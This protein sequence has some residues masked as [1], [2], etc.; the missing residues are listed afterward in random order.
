MEE[1]S[2]MDHEHCI[3]LSAS[4]V[5]RRAAPMA[6]DKRSTINSVLEDLQKAQCYQGSLVL[7]R[8][9]RKGT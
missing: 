5:R 8:D 3:R 9:D 4:T 1:G 2:S 7:G 6:R